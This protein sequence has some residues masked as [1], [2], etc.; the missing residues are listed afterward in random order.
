MTIKPQSP[1]PHSYQQHY[2]VH[3][4]L[5]RISNT[6]L[7]VIKYLVLQHFLISH[8]QGVYYIS[9]IASENVCI[10][11]PTHHIEKSNIFIINSSHWK[12]TLENRGV[13]CGHE[14]TTLRHF[15]HSH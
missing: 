13:M 5:D 15:T 12:I 8:T 2:L 3:K 1:H 14:D 9:T 10:V 6:I 4:I 11:N 7:H